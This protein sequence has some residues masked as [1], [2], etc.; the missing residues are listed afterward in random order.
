MELFIPKEPEHV[1]ERI[2]SMS[3]VYV[4]TPGVK[5]DSLDVWYGNQL[6]KYLWGEWKG[7]L[8]PRGFTWQKFLRLLKHRTDAI[9][10]WHKGL[11]TWEQ[12]AQDTINLIEGPLGKEI[13]KR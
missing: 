9:L 8:K 11:Y 1:K 2:K 5:W 4:K 3:K 7:V 12:F 13:A 10:L 6:P